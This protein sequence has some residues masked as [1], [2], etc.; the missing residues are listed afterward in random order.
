MRP[1]QQKQFQ[2]EPWKKIRTV[3]LPKKTPRGL[4]NFYQVKKNNNGSGCLSPNFYNESSPFA[5]TCGD[6]EKNRVF[7]GFEWEVNFD[8]T[9]TQKELKSRAEKV[10]KKHI[11]KGEKEYFQTSLN[12]VQNIN[13]I[14]LQSLIRRTIA[15]SMG[16]KTPLGNYLNAHGDSGDVEIVSVP[17]TLT[18]HREYLNSLVFTGRNNFVNQ[19]LQNPNN[20][21]YGQYIGI[22]VHVDRR[23][24]TENSLAKTLMFFSN[25]NNKDFIEGV[26]GRWGHANK[27]LKMRPLFNKNGK[28]V[29]PKLK[30]SD[31]LDIQRG[32]I[33][34]EKYKNYLNK[35]MLKTTYTN[36]LNTQRGF[37]IAIQSR[38][39][40][41]EFRLFSTTNKKEVLLKR[42][43]FVDAIVRYTRKTAWSKLTA[44]DFCEWVL[45]QHNNQ[46]RE[47]L[48]YSNLI[49]SKEFKKALKRKGKKVN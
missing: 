11:P 19:F 3:P 14:C 47:F 4:K 41:I 15:H 45:E 7:M 23:C 35:S 8:R 20:N 44:E 43:E 37:H 22:H 34:T 28:I 12:S 29:N 18:K 49:E 31:P 27:P 32:F 24:F 48:N 39:P 13:F 21:S 1:T 16:H 38:K 40:T 30:L 46:K 26:A 17:C 10:L 2:V 25:P 42:L 9:Q 33:L 36:T 5:F 6:N